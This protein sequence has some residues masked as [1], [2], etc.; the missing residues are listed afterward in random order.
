MTKND[1]GNSP[2]FVFETKD[3]NIKEIVGSM[4]TIFSVFNWNNYF[5]DPFQDTKLIKMLD[6]LE[7]YIIKN[8]KGE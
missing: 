2:I 3:F 4:I 7:K 8:Y 1:K 5:K 6:N